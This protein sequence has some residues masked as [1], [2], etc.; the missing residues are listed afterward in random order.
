MG[1]VSTGCTIVAVVG[2]YLGWSGS[3]RRDRLLVWTLDSRHFEEIQMIIDHEMRFELEGEKVWDICTRLYSLTDFGEIVYYRTYSRL[4]ADG[5]QERWPETV[6]RVINGLFTIRKWWMELHHLPWD[7]SRMQEKAFDMALSMLDMKWLPPG[8]GLWAMGTDYIYER[9]A[10]AL[11]NCA[12]VAVDDLPKDVSWLMDALM[13]GV[14]VGFGLSDRNPPKLFGPQDGGWIYKIPDSREGWVESVK[15]LLESYCFSRTKYVEF[16]YSLIRPYGEPISGFG[17][18]ASGP[19]PLHLLHQRIRVYCDNYIRGDIGWTELVANLCNAVGVCVVVGNVRRSAE[20]YLGSPND[21]EFMSLKDYEVKPERMSIGWMSNN[22]ARLRERNDFLKIPTIADHIQVRGEP[23]VYNEINVQRY[24]R[25]GDTS[26]GPD[27][28]TGINP[29]GEVPLESYEVCNLAEVFPTRCG[30]KREFL[31]AVEHATFYASTVSLFPTHS[32][33]T[34]AVVARNRRI[35]VSLSGIAEWGDT[36]GQAR[37]TRW[38]KEGYRVARLVN[39]A[40]NGEAGIGPSLRVTTVKPSG[41][42]SQLANVPSGMHY[43]TSEYA[44][45]RI[46][47]DTHCDIA[48]VLRDAGYPEEPVVEFLT[49]HEAGDREVFLKY[50]QFSPSD[51]VRSW[52]SKDSSVFEVPVY[53]GKARA[54]KDVSAWEQ[55]SILAWLQREWAD[56]SVSC[57]I[58]FDPKEEGD[59]VPQML[60]QFVPVIKSVSMLPHTEKGV[61]CQMPYEE[62][63]KEEY[64]ERRKSLGK[65]SWD[66]VQADGDQMATLYCEGDKCELPGSVG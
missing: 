7:E 44:I 25:Y 18:R 63:S 22:S 17:G 47:M 4:K 55:F 9:G 13:C 30:T 56:N 43:P 46:I 50:D 37:C 27:K 28:A 38:I 51:N 32:T 52:K 26:Y 58:Y 45:R 8:R 66:G 24:A 49:E 20:I 31:V 16:D 15:L 10:M 36:W 19:E 48:Q 11:Y 53:L 14:G 60:A 12:Y 34:N 41:T 54:A 21:Q 64:E 39:A 65:L 3:V 23:G 42:I 1:L 6:V 57:T 35:G 40:A 5:S 61:Y 33:R 59:Q 62:I 29:C 2:C